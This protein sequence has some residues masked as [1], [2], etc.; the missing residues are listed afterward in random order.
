MWC[1]L[2]PVRWT[3]DP[4]PAGTLLAEF[5]HEP[6]TIR[7]GKSARRIV[8]SN[9]VQPDLDHNGDQHFLGGARRRQDCDA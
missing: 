8:T 7:V 4:S 5:L 1:G 3:N 6:A 9:L 2:P